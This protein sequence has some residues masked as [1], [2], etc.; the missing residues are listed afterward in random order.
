MKFTIL[1]ALAAVALATPV[2]D[3]PSPSAS[4]EHIEVLRDDR[5]HDENGHYNFEF[6]SENGISWS[7][8]GSPDG[9]EGAIVA[10]GEYSYV[11]PDGTEVVVKYV[12][13]EN[14]F[15]PQSDLLP[16]APEFPHPIPRFVLDQI[17]FA[18]AEDR[19]RALEGSHERP[20]VRSPS[21]TYRA[22]Q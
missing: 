4:H 5:H 3:A 12:A 7:E 1:A 9:D 13:N 8:G 6:E 14:G 22:P 21:G 11:A 15:Q 17:A 10:A 20:S 2:Y 18:E 16:V 19:L